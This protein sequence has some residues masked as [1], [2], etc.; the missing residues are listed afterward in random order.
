MLGSAQALRATP[1]KQFNGAR[2]ICGRAPSVWPV[3]TNGPP[4]LSP[5]QAAARRP[6]TRLSQRTLCC[7]AAFQS[8]VLQR[9][10]IRG[11]AASALAVT[12]DDMLMCVTVDS[13][14]HSASWSKSPEMSW[15]RCWASSFCRCTGECPNSWAVISGSP[16]VRETT[17]SGGSANSKV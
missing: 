1:A 12:D 3:C 8:C 4:R 16:P 5:Q 17:R 9:T 13:S 10:G 14:A 15:K 7:A 6:R 11:G 2:T